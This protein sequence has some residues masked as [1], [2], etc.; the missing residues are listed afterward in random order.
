M[1]DHKRKEAS[2]YYFDF[3]TARQILSQCVSLF[4]IVFKTY[5]SVD[6]LIIIVVVTC[7]LLL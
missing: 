6:L 5:V 4:V 7:E 2:G 1:H 3:S